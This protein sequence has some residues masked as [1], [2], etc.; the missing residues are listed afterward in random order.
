[1]SKH[2]PH[3]RL[4]SRELRLLHWMVALLVV[5][6]VSGILARQWLPAGHE[7][8]P[9]MRAVHLTAGQLVLVAAVL[10][11]VARL[12]SP[13]NT[14]PAMPWFQAWTARLVH[15]GLYAVIF[16]QP[17]TGILFSQAGDKKVMLFG[18]EWPQLVG[19]NVDLHFALKY[20]HQ[21]IAV[22]LYGLLS[23]HV[24]AALW[25]HF[26]K[27]DNTLR[28]M[29]GLAARTAT[30]ATAEAEPTPVPA[31]VP[32]GLTMDEAQRHRV[33]EGLR[34]ESATAQFVRQVAPALPESRPEPAVVEK[35]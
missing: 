20:A 22:G 17:V 9:L 3:R 16:L 29:L 24:A 2:L 19:S 18:L 14:D 10:R 31:P 4:P 34:G 5:V 8:R 32:L 15:F 28:H 27:R 12:R 26:V 35:V 21:N 30:P 6:A 33:I 7:Y 1:M 13:M 11:L 23:I 25:H